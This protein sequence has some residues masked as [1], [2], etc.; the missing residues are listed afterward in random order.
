MVQHDHGTTDT[1]YPKLITID[2]WQRMRLKTTVSFY[3]FIFTCLYYSTDDLGTITKKF[4]CA[5]WQHQQRR[6]CIVSMQISIALRKLLKS[7]FLERCRIRGKRAEGKQP[8]QITEG[9]WRLK[10]CV[11]FRISLSFLVG[12][13]FVFWVSFL[14]LEFRRPALTVVTV[15]RLIVVS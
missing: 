11:S 2:V 13:F 3:L 4:D 15:G 8:T 6:P 9:F 10:F 12:V 5:E 7:R 1:I 14:T